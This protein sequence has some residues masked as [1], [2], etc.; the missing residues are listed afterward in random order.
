MPHKQSVIPLLDHVDPMAQRIGAINTI[1]V[2]PDGTLKGFNNN[3]VGFVQSISDAKPDWRPGSV[4]ILVLGA[5][6]SARAVVVALVDQ[7]AREIRVANRT[8]ERAERLAAEIGTLVSVLPWEHRNDAMAEVGL[9]VNATDRGMVASPPLDVSLTRLRNDAIVGD[10]IYT[11]VGDL[12]YTPP[13][14]P[15]L[16]G[17]LHHCPQRHV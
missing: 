1:V 2:Q 9:L 14:T 12:I 5:G 6:G 4:P 16:T 15:L 17:V 11:P 7:G 13:E 3:G 10:L 8:P